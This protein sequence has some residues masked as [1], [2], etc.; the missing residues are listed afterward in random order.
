MYILDTWQTFLK[1]TI[2]KKILHGIWRLLPLIFE[3]FLETKQKFRLVSEPLV[4]PSPSTF[5]LL[6]ALDLR[7]SSEEVTKETEP[8]VLFA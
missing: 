8:L 4:K 1:L 2:K 5:I 6:L 7:P 3:T